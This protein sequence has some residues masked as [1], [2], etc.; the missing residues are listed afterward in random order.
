MKKIMIFTNP[1][2][3]S[4]LPAWI[5]MIGYLETWWTKLLLTY[6]SYGDKRGLGGDAPNGVRALT[7]LGASPL[8]PFCRG[9]LRRVW[10]EGMWVIRKT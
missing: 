3:T 1:T 2:V 5:V 8:N 10:D 9:G 6:Y 4:H 7:P